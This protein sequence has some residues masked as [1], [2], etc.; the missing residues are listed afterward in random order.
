MT[1]LTNSLPLP[2]AGIAA[3][4]SDEAAVK[5]AIPAHAVRVE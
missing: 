5:R 4:D 1:S 3:I 2:K